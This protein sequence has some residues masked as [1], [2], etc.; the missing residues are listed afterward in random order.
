MVFHMESYYCWNTF[1]GSRWSYYYPGAMSTNQ[2]LDNSH[3][4]IDVPL[5]Q[6]DSMSSQPIPK[7]QANS[8]LL[9]P[10]KADYGPSQS[11]VFYFP[12]SSL[13][14]VP[15]C[16]PKDRQFDSQSGHMP[17]LQARIPVG[18]TWEATTHGCFSPSLSPSLPLSLKINKYNL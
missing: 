3:V 7:H 12:S 15:A 8:G 5:D 16:E 18:G 4:P 6:K 13:D 10:N 17:G 11:G 1:P 2:N 14:S 9:T